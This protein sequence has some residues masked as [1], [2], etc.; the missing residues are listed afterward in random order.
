MTLLAAWDYSGVGATIPDLSGSGRSFTLTGTSVR[1]AAGGGF[2]YGGSRPAKQGLTQNVAE[3][4]LGPAIAGMNT[5]AR[6][7]M[8]Y[9]KGVPINPSWFLKYYRASGVDTGVFGWLMLSSVFQGRA[10]DPSNS[11]FDITTATDAANF[12]HRAL[13]YDGANFRLYHDAVLI[14]TLPFAGGVWAADQFHVFDGAGSIV[15]SDTRIFDTALTQSEIATWM[16][17][18]LDNS[19]PMNLGRA[20]ESDVAHRVAWGKDLGLGPATENDVPHRLAWNKA[21]QL[22]RTGETD[23]VHPLA[24]AKQPDLGPATETDVV[25]PVTWSKQPGLERVTETD[26]VHPMSWRKRFL[27]RTAMEHDAAHRMST[28]GPFDPVTDPE[29]RIRANPAE[30]TLRPNPAEAT[31]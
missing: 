29:A 4:Q 10:K 15:L 25:H 5:P 16:V 13:T 17:T 27:L 23:V 14:G 24:W 12:H 8:T 7:V 30:A 26:I 28:G 20:T 3:I 2:T 31:I 9:Q 22:R 6:T 21:P 11:A 19:V 1:T 18:P